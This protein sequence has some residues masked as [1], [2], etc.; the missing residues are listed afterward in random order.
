MSKKSHT[1]HIKNAHDLEFLKLHA[2]TH[3]TLKSKIKMDFVTYL[4]N[5]LKKSKVIGWNF[6][7][8]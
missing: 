8:H 5:F 3:P 6:E 1:V 2:H 7:Q 4:P